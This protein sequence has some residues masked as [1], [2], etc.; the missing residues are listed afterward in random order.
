MQLSN[1]VRITVVACATAIILGVV[2]ALVITGSPID[3]GDILTGAGV[4]LGGLL[5][6]V[7]VAG[8]RDAARNGTPYP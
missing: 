8:G 2:A 4:L 7:G 6:G 1:P 3:A 5:Y